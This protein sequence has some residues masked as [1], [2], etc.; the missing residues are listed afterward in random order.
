MSQIHTTQDTGH[1]NVLTFQNNK[2]YTSIQQIEDEIVHIS[3]GVKFIMGITHAMVYYTML[4]AMDAIK[5][6]DGQDKR[7]VLYYFKAAKKAMDNHLSSLLHAQENRFFA[8]RDMSDEMRSKYKKGLT[9]REYFEYWLDTGASA[10]KGMA[11]QIKV[12]RNKYLLALKER[13]INNA[14]IVAWAVLM[15][16]LLGEA[17]KVYQESILGTFAKNIGLPVKIM[18]TIYGSFRMKSA[19]MTWQRALLTLCPEM[20]TLYDGIRTERNVV[21][22]VNDF[23]EA[24]GKQLVTTDAVMEATIDNEDLWADKASFKKAKSSIR[25]VEK[26]MREYKE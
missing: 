20:R 18:E 11:T 21:L 3:G 13:D 14:D 6:Y 2:G 17:D 10:Y 15:Q 26:A 5:Q 7:Y 8:V 4:D 24:L 9:D 22:G 23:E 1:I 12:M 16:F 19:Q 25:K